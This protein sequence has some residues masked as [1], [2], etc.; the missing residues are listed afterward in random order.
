M[1]SVILP[2]DLGS[3]ASQLSLCSTII[4]VCF[5]PIHFPELDAILSFAAFTTT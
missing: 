4:V 2:Y 1:F 5:Y 3:S